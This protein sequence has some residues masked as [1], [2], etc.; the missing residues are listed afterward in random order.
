MAVNRT[1]VQL[2]PKAVLFSDGMGF[3][4]STSQST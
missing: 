2:T 1:E 3:H 4:W